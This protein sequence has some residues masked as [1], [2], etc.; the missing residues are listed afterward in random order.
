ME[1]EC[2]ESPAIEL[3]GVTAGYG[4]APVLRD[5]SLRVERGECVALLGPNGVGKSSLLRVISGQLAVTQG[6]V[7]LNGRLLFDYAP[8]QRARLLTC[9]SQELEGDLPYTASE[10]VMLGRT[11]WLPLVGGVSEKDRES[12]R[13]SM[14]WT[15][16]LAFADRPFWQ[17]SGGERQRLTLAMVLA[18]EPQILL[19]DEPTA[20]LDLRHGSDFLRLLLRLN[21]EKGITIVTVVH[22]LTLASQFF[23]RLI[24]LDEGKI[25][26]D[27]SSSEVLCEDRISAVYHCPVKTMPLDHAGAICVLVEREKEVKSESVGKSVE[28]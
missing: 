20:H 1:R 17:M 25:V 26:A 3:N 27:G 18:G 16:T 2:R 19:L 23:P 10:Y 12:V 13:E 14:E 4:H 6:V 8:R 9:V 21:R 22:D 11:P 15:E 28:K 5:V 24:L 7:R